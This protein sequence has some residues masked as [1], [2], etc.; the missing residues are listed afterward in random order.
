MKEN[1]ITGTKAARIIGVPRGTIIKW[2]NKDKL[3]PVSGSSI[4]G[5]GIAKMM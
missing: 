5:F 3:I 4:D 2:K 1:V